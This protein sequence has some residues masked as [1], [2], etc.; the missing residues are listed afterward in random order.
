MNQGRICLTS[1]AHYS[2]L[3]WMIAFS[4]RSVLVRDIRGGFSPTKNPATAAGFAKGELLKLIQ[5]GYAV[6]LRAF[7]ALNDLK[8]HLIAFLQAF[9]AFRGDGAVMD[10]HVGSVL[11]TDETK[12]FSV[13]EPFDLTANSCHLLVPPNRSVAPR[14]VGISQC[15]PMRNDILPCLRS[16][17]QEPGIA[18]GDWLF[19]CG[20]LDLRGT[21]VDLFSRRCSLLSRE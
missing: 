19:D 2:Y 8:F 1:A 4:V 16:G 5:L 15:D 14:R 9:V 6:G 7:L 21:W 11:V 12:S 17:V 10:E 3:N 18:P 20:R 13:V